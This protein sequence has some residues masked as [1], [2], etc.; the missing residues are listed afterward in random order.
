MAGSRIE[1][2][3]PKQWGGDNGNGDQ[4][5]APPRTAPLP[6]T[7]RHPSHS[8]EKLLKHAA[9]AMASELEA[10]GTPVGQLLA[11]RW[12]EVEAIQA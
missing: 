11:Q 2:V 12:R 4:P 7:C 6:A 8:R 3:D 1:T 9:D 10:T 5:P